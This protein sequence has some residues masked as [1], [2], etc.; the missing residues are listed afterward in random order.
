VLV[1]QDADE[2]DCVLRK[3]L[4][5]KEDEVLE[6]QQQLDDQSRRCGTVTFSQGARPAES[7]YCAG[8]CGTS[9]LSGTKRHTPDAHHAWANGLTDHATVPCLRKGHLAE[10]APCGSTV[11]FI[12]GA[13]LTVTHGC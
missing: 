2:D 8:V 13:H 3:Q 1:L 9:M 7:R 10:V 12:Q 6:L 5:D 11:G 4:A